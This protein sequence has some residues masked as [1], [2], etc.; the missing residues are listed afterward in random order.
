MFNHRWED[1]AAA[2]W[3]W[4]VKLTK[5]K[6][7]TV[8]TN[9]GWVVSRCT[10]TAPLQATRPCRKRANPVYQANLRRH[11]TSRRRG[12]AKSSNNSNASR[13]IHPTRPP[14]RRYLKEPLLVFLLSSVPAHRY[15]RTFRS[16]LN[17]ASASLKH[18]V[19]KVS[20]S[21]AFQ[22]IVSPLTPL[23]IRSI[24]VHN[25]LLLFS[26]VLFLFLL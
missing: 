16:L 13:V 17:C 9:G 19:W 23:P 1:T 15:Q 21:T 4:C 25:I 7:L 8:P 24:K 5:S 10:E 22:A 20:A 2:R 18:A 6:T 12:G 11:R 14:I 3:F 26:V